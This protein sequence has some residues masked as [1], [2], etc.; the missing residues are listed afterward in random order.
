MR[1]QGA[2]PLP[3]LAHRYA[4]VAVTLAFLLL[5]P[6]S[7]VAALPPDCDGNSYAANSAFQANLNLLAAALPVN[8]SASPAGFATAA[9]GTV[10]DQANG[11]ALCRGD[12]NASTCAACVAAAFRDAQQAC[13]LN[14]GAKVYRDACF[15]RF[16]ARRFLDFLR[17]DQWLISELVYELFASKFQFFYLKLLPV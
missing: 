2:P 17:D 16:A 4:T 13:P 14:K 7:A 11:L 3:L 12:T 8:A 1:K 10:P 5:P 6:P 9:V 15:L